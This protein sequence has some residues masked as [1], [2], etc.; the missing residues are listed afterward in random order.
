MQAADGVRNLAEKKEIQSFLGNPVKTDCNNNLIKAERAP[1]RKIIQNPSATFRGARCQNGDILNVGNAVF[2]RD[3]YDSD[4]VNMIV[5]R[6][7]P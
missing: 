3:E 5:K 4:Q 2:F 1:N 6:F 7:M